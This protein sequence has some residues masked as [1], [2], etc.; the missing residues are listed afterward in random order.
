MTGR[1]LAPPSMTGL[2][3]PRHLAVITF[4]LPAKRTVV[5]A[6]RCG[7]RQERG[8]PLDQKARKPHGRRSAS[9]HFNSPKALPRKK[10]LQPNSQPQF[11]P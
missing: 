8:A 4:Q 7:L 10:A 5:V 6:L 1:G 3:W 2:G 9:R 11:D